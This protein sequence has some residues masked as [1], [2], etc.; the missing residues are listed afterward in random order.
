MSI[1]Q[2]RRDVRLARSR[3]EAR[4]ITRIGEIA[5]A[6]SQL[7]PLSDREIALALTAH[8]VT[9]DPISNNNNI[10]CVESGVVRFDA[11]G[12]PGG[13]SHAATIGNLETAT[14]AA[15]VAAI[16]TTLERVIP[17]AIARILQKDTER[18]AGEIA[19]WD[20]VSPESAI[21]R[22]QARGGSSSPLR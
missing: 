6:L 21:E 9:L 11:P 7:R 20:S 17:P 10:Y 2:N 1:E 22:A 15:I 12:Y 16:V 4:L 5:H 8:G 13:E 3:C 14:D 19:L 18:T